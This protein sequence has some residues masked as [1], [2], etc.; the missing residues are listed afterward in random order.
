MSPKALPR[1]R[2]SCTVWRRPR[3]WLGAEGGTDVCLQSL[4]QMTATPFSQVLLLPPVP[5]STAHPHPRECSPQG[6]LSSLECPVI[7][8]MQ[9]RGHSIQEDFLDKAPMASATP[10]SACGTV[11]PRWRVLQSGRHNSGEEDAKRTPTPD[12][13]HLL[14]LQ[15]REDLSQGWWPST[16]PGS[17]TFPMRSCLCSPK[18]ITAQDWLG[19]FNSS[20]ADPPSPASDPP[21]AL[22]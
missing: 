11:C 5:P 4:Y 10:T 7:L 16:F 12:R 18:C 21:T 6:P 1:R 9:L 2:E 17:R 22:T 19:R 20:W 13:W 3:G 8:Q 14:G 15:N